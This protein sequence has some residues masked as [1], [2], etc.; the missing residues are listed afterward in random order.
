MAKLSA[1]PFFAN[2]GGTVEGALRHYSQMAKKP[3]TQWYA[4]Q[5]RK[6]KGLT[7]EE[8]SARLDDMAISYLSDLE[9]GKARWNVDHLDA[10][11]FAYGI[12]PEDLLWNPDAPPP[13]WV[14]INKIAPG[15]RANAAKALE[16]FAKKTGTGG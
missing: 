9:K 10:F 13:L 2:G 1:T 5:W 3:K 6:K 8:A 11:A 14:I 4:R 12:E 7:L 16:G 15:E